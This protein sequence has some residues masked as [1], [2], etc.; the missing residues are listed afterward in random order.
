MRADDQLGEPG[1][2]WGVQIAD[3]SAPRIVP[4]NVLSARYSPDGSRVAWST[5][6]RN[7]TWSIGWIERARDCVES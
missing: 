6:T 4:D 7:S 1:P 5:G 2:L 3:G